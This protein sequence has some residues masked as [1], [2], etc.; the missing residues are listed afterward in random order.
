M[1]YVKYAVF[2]QFQ[3]ALL[4]LIIGSEPLSNGDVEH[5]PAPPTNNNTDT[6]NV[7]DKLTNDL[8]RLQ[9]YV[10]KTNYIFY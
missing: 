6:N 5:T 8:L 3:D 4:D 1:S 10:Y 2:V 9:C 7:S